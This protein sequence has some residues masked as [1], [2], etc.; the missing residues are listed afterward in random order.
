M[1]LYFV[2]KFYFTEVKVLSSIH[3]NTCKYYVCGIKLETKVMSLH[4]IRVEKISVFHIKK[5][6]VNDFWLL[7]VMF[8]V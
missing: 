5:S 7:P 2:T 3:L 4:K 8:Q 6:A 1:G